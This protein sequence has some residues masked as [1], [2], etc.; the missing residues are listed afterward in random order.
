M[1]VASVDTLLVSAHHLQDAARLAVFDGIS[2]DRSVRTPAESPGSIQRAAC[3]RRT[4]H[5][6]GPRRSPSTESRHPA[7]YRGTGAP[8]PRRQPANSCRSSSRSPRNR[9]GT[10]RRPSGRSPPNSGPMMSRR[11]HPASVN[12][13]PA[14]RPCRDRAR[15]R[16]SERLQPLA[17][18]RAMRLRMR[19]LPVFGSSLSCRGTAS[20]VPAIGVSPNSRSQRRIASSRLIPISSCCPASMSRHTIA[21]GCRYTRLAR[22]VACR[23]ATASFQN[24]RPAAPTSAGHSPS[25]DPLNGGSFRL[26]RSRAALP[27]FGPLFTV[28]A[29]ITQKSSFKWRP[30]DESAEGGVPASCRP[31]GLSASQLA[32][33]HDAPMT[34]SADRHHGSARPRTTDRLVRHERGCD[35]PRQPAPCVHARSP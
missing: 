28:S 26:A 11:C 5:A 12:G 32:L 34:R 7:R 27:V 15:A 16:R 3:T 6:P 1:R 14:C 10:C 24:S 25:P 35:A 17:A 29:P 4:R 22:P 18:F 30:R 21:S 23:C 9:C 8:A 33:V 19:A 13:C 2:I 31:T 20:V